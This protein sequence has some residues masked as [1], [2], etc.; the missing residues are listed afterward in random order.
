[1]NYIALFMAVFSVL[2]G[3]DRIIGNRF[4]IGAEFER[5]MKM[6]G[7][8]TLSMVGMIVIAPS[9]AKLLQPL[10]SAMT[11]ALDPSVITAMLFANDMGGA[12]L[13]VAVGCNAELAEFNALVVSSMMGCTVSFT[14]PYVFA[15]VPEAYRRDVLMGL[16]W[17]IVTIPVGCLAAG[18]VAGIYFPYLLL[19]LVPMVILSALIA[20]GLL[21]APGVSVKI[22]TCLGYFIKLL[23]TVGLI[24]G[25]IE[26]LVGVKIIPM[27]DSLSVGVE[28][29]VYIACVMTG[30]FPFLAIVSRILRR[31]L[32]YLGKKM[33]INDV[34]AL[35]LFSCLATSITVFE[36]VGKMDR[37]G[38]RLNSAFAVSAAFVFADHLA[39]TL[40]FSEHYLLPVTVGKLVSGISALLLAAFMT[41]G[42]K[43]RPSGIADA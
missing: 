28:T 33:G 14:V 7:P 13:S 23:V 8:L 21:F 29:V 19:D 9:V 15:T 4:G 6:L 12:Q 32:S 1:M 36:S 39:F 5:G 27:S 10:T 38:I 3:I 43:A 24:A 25:I 11:G 31:P 35:S 20:A 42:M 40:S 2:G 41:R 34:S 16:L 30:A 26:L 22:F 17:G 18:L 37:R